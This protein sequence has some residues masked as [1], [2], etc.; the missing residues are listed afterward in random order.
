MRLSPAKIEYLAEKLVRIMRD[1]EDVSLNI[2]ADELVRIIEWEFVDELKVED[3]IDAEVNVL[4]E[5][6][7]RQIMS[8]DLDQMML[9]RKLK[10]ELAKK[11]GYTL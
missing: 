3:E 2:P 10:Q 4:L 11:R 6:Y 7:E 1:H 5:Q 9:R 8:Q